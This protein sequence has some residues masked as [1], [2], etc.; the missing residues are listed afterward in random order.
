MK[1]LFIDYVEF[2]ITN[3][4]NLTCN[5]CNRF[6]DRNFTGYQSWSDYRDQYREW[7]QELDIGYM[8]IMG[9]EPLM[10]PT[11]YEWVRGLMELWPGR[12]II[13]PINGTLLH[14]HPQLYPLLQAHPE[15]LLDVSLHNKQHKQ[16]IIDD[17]KNFLTAP[18]TYEFDNTQYQEKLVITDAYGVRVIVRYSWWFHQ[19]ALTVDAETGRPTLHNSDPEK[20]HSICHSQTCHHFGRGRLYKCGPAALFP[21]LDQQHPLWLTAEQRLRMLSV[22]SIGINDTLEVKQH[23]ID[24]IKDPIPQCSL[25]P[26]SY[27]GQQIFS[28]EK[29]ELKHVQR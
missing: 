19:G 24:R 28:I 25:C 29:R 6:N 15:L 13:I 17:I 5:G 18:F 8:S 1:P 11:F 21:E 16:K 26:E 3:N 14:K 23:F 27:Q 20:A 2:Y 12:R 4:C 10:N 22:N 9:G 7:S